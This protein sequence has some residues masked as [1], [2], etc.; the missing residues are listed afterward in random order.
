MTTAVPGPYHPRMAF[1]LVAVPIIV[2][3][4]GLAFLYDCRVRARRRRL[5]EAP[6][7]PARS[8]PELSPEA[9]MWYNP[10]HLG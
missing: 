2:I 9:G 5:G 8:V 10:P 1:W 7:N 4:L 6:I 3:G